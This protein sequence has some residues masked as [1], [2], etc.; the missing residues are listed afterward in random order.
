MQK[1]YAIIFVLGALIVAMI[2][3]MSIFFLIKALRRAKKIGMDKKLLTGAIK[4]SAIFSIV[5][6]IPIV[7]GVGIMMPALGIAIPWIRLTVIGALQYEV[8]GAYVSGAMAPSATA[9]DI[10]TAII[11]MTLSII[12]GPIFN[13]TFYKRYQSK[14][15]A[16]QETNKRKMDTIT[17]ALLAGML[18]GIMSALIVGGA[19]GVNNPVVDNNTGMVTYG[20]V[21]LITLSVS[22]GIMIISGI[23]LKVTKQKWIESYA[24]PASILVSL[25]AAFFAVPAFAG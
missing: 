12:S 13:A 17:G 4:N 19:F 7:V 18:A 11:V 23:L 1:D 14:L 21:T 25:L 5:P 20:E 15:A 3:A 24:L 16:I 6:S 9:T 8:S 10:A 2:I 22:M